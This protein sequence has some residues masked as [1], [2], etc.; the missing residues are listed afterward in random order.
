MKKIFFYSIAVITTL[1]GSAFTIQEIINWKINNENAQV[2]FSMKAHGQEL[3]GNFKNVKGDIKFDPNDLA[4]SS[5]NCNV[6]VASIN[7]G[8]PE[9]NGHL[10]GAKWFD[11]ANYPNINFT[12]SKIEKTEAGYNAVGTLS[13]KGVQKETSIPFK[14]TAKASQGSAGTFEGSFSIKRSDFTVGKTDGDVG[15]DVLLE[16]AIPVEKAK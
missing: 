8:V 3:I 14:F 13:I 11:A 12:S 6:E 9:R 5:F 10:Q 15:D 7:T 2:K 16:L 1:I 4:N